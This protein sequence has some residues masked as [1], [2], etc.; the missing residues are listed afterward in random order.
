MQL[1]D[2]EYEALARLTHSP[3]W[4]VVE[5]VLERMHSEALDRLIG[6]TDIHNVHRAQGSA[7]TLR[8]F[9]KLARQSTEIARK[10]RGG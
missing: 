2:T 5:P 3:E 9:L 1:T 10:K 8:E 7:T 4:R 6:A